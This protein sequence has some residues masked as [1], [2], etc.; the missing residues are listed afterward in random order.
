MSKLQLTVALHAHECTTALVDG[1]VAIEGCD[2]NFLNLPPEETFHRAFGHHEFDVCE[3]SSS[4]YLIEHDR[5]GGA[6]IALPVFTLRR[7]RHG[8]IYVRAGAGIEQPSD[9]RGKLVGVP[10]YQVTAVLW[11]RGIL[12]D[13]FGVEPEEVRWRTGGINQPGR[14]EK[15]PVSIP[16]VE[17]EAIPADATL[18]DWLHEGRLDAVIAPRPIAEGGP[19][20]VRRLFADYQEVERAWFAR[21][22][23]Y[24]IMHLVGVRRA[25]TEANPWLPSSLY[26][27][28]VNARD[29]M[30]ERYRAVA[31]GA[32]AMIL[33]WAQEVVREGLA[34]L[35][36]HIWPYGVEA[37]RGEL[38]TLVR[39]S[40]RQQLIR[41]AH[42][43]EDLFA[44]ATVATYRI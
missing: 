18:S 40:H 25:L 41:R 6:Y 38:E 23:L 16:G 13:E 22:G 17:I 39:Y 27:A 42:P 10:E 2:A 14:V 3:L 32:D 29:T 30:L 37:N 33:P 12:A 5:G 43:I 15:L 21:T 7:F 1:R 4:S 19:Q 9:L 8:A 44:P 20:R 34:A 11:A 28:F 24:P 26:K 35:G 36:D 31:A